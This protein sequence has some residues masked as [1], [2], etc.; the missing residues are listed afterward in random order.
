MS[1][2]V[3]LTTPAQRA[4]Y[5]REA[6]YV[7]RVHTMPVVGPEYNDAVHSYNAVSLLLVLHPGPSVRLIRRLLWHDAG[8]RIAG[9]IPHPAKKQ[10]PEMAA[11]YED[12]ERRALEKYGLLSSGLTDEEE[13][14]EHAMDMLEFWMWCRDQTALGNGLVWEA[15]ENIVQV[16][17]R[18]RAADKLP[19]RVCD[20]I[21]ELES[22]PVTARERSWV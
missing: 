18:L 5:A 2:L 8:E 10:K 9:D 3:P 19:R 12:L 15:H 16:L 4:R 11:S 13:V 22:T 14:W 7:R 6:G 1:P 17:N 20:F 21:E